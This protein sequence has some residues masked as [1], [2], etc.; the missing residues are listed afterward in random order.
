M[1]AASAQLRSSR[2]H[3]PF[4]LT[5]VMRTACY[6]ALQEL[7]QRSAA[8]ADCSKHEERV[9][10]AVEHHRRLLL[11]VVHLEHVFL[12]SISCL[13]LSRRATRGCTRTWH[14]AVSQLPPPQHATA[15][16]Q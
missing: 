14:L 10:L 7:L 5:S 3:R 11:P 2:S 15:A 4:A 1:L 8:V 6:I 13:G 16:P 9:E 12:H